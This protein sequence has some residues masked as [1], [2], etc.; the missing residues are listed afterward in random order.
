MH[1]FNFF[2]Y[3][4]ITLL[5]AL[6]LTNT[7]GEERFWE[8]PSQFTSVDSRFP[9]SISASAGGK[10]YSLLFFEEVEEKKSQL[11][12][13]AKLTTDGKMWRDIPRFAG[14]YSYVGSVP[15]QYATAYNDDGIVCVAVIT[16]IGT[17]SV[18]RTDMA[19]VLQG[20][21][22][23]FSEKALPAI[24]NPLLAPRIYKNG[25]N[26][27]TL[28]S[29]QGQE[30][31]F[32][33]LYS[34]SPDGEA[35][36]DFASF[37][38]AESTMN[39]FL[40]VL[41]ADDKVI[42]QAQYNNGSR[43]VY[44][45]Y[46]TQYNADSD[47]WEEARLITGKDSF[48]YEKESSRYDSYNNQ[49]PFVFTHHD[50]TYIAW[51]RS[52]ST[53]DQPHI[54]FSEFDG[55]NFV[56]STIQEL[57]TSGS[58]HR[59]ILFSSD[60]EALAILWFDNRRGFDSVF[61]G[62]FFAGE[63]DGSVISR[64]N[65]PSSFAYPVQVGDTLSFVWQQ[66]AKTKGKSNVYIL[67]KDHSVPRP[68]LKPISYTLGKRSTAKKVSAQIIAG[69][70]SSGIAGYS[71]IFTQDRDA[72]V[73]KVRK[74]KTK[75]NTM[76]ASANDDGL[77]YFK[78]RCEDYAGN[79]SDVATLSY[80]RDTTPPLKPIISEPNKDADG[81]ISSNT[82]S[83]SW[84]QNPQD[85]DV[86]G[87]SWSL[88]YVATEPETKTLSS[89]LKK[90]SGKLKS[91][92]PPRTLMGNKR[93]S[94][95]NNLKN[96]VYIFSVAAIDQVGNIGQ[97]ASVFVSLNKYVAETKVTAVDVN[98]SELHEISMSIFGTDFTYRGTISEVY[99]DRDGNA[100]Y[101]KV[102]YLANGDYEVNSDNRISGI[103]THDLDEGDYKVGLLHTKRGVYFTGD[104][105]HVEQNGT[106]KF[107]HEYDYHPI[108]IPYETKARFI[109]DMPLVLLC[110]V[111]ILAFCSAVGAIKGMT[112]TVEEL[113]FIRN[114]IVAIEEGKNMIKKKNIIS[115]NKQFGL[116]LKLVLFTVILVMM[117]VS[118]VSIP[119]G[120]FTNSI[121]E[122][123]LAS[124]LEERVNVLL[125]S[126]S[127]GV[128]AYLPLEN[129]LEL[130]N[131]PAQ[132]SALPE[133]MYATISG[134]P[135]GSGNTNLDYVWA[136][137]DENIA[138]KIDSEL[139]YGVS[140]FTDEIMEKISLDFV[141]LNSI[142]T[143][144][145]GAIA[146]SIAQLNAE[147]AELALKDDIESEKRLEELSTITMQLSSRLNQMLSDISS[148]TTGSYPTYDDEHIDPNENIYIFY[149]PVLYRQ[150]SEQN[151]I[152][153]IIYVTVDTTSLIK[154]VA[155]ARRTV[156]FTALSITLIAVI[157]GGV[158]AL[159]VASVIVNPV[160]K[161]EK[162]VA[163]ISSTKDKMKLA[164]KDILVKT[165]DEIAS[166]G[167]KINEMTHG[168][169][170]AAE[171]EQLMMDGKVV[172]QAFL[173]LLPLGKGK[174]SISEFKS[175][176]LHF[177]GYYE[178][179]SLVSGDYFDYRELDKQWFTVIK[180]DAS[181]HGVPAALIVTVVATFFRKYCEGW[182]FKKNGT[183]IGECVL[184]INEFLS[185]LGLQGKFA[186]IC[187]C[188]INMDSG[189]V[190]T[191]NA[192]DNI[193]HIYDGKQKKMIIR[194]MF[195]NPAAGN[196]SAQFVR[197]VLMQELEFKVEKIHLEKDDVLFLYTDG[198][199]ES[200]RKYRNTD[201]SEL[202]VEETS[203][204][205]TPYAHT[206]KVDHEQMEND[207][208][209]AIIE[210][211]MSKSTY[212]LEKKHNPLLDERLEFDFST[213]DGTNEDIIIALCSVEKVFRFYKSP[214]VTEVDTVRC[215]KKI[216]EFLSKHFNRYDY[217]CSRKNEAFENPIY[218]EYLFL[219]EDEQLD[220]LTMLSIT[221]Q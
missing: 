48:I 123:T 209:H 162:H 38:P 54:W 187:M 106:I 219:R 181:G 32:S 8:Y 165:N 35:W 27:F 194:K 2:K 13:S 60:G 202:E 93:Q 104:V 199:E 114:D 216:D 109:I 138:D 40:P 125:E 164:G 31:S 134:I 126:L 185:S 43:L 159:I 217:Y 119:L 198:I 19:S 191:C 82:F 84:K 34:S 133:A 68:S 186:A 57:T 10:N 161:L 33:M 221:R 53:S 101:D 154:S 22:V 184:Q 218:V 49:R 96:G 179:A 6:S 131:L 77:W 167:E 18:F 141:E 61:F 64:S 47:S 206:E 55:E 183:R 174:M 148:N 50:K 108:W 212:V 21:E 118:L 90:L 180:C 156:I 121:Q 177:F 9:S 29:S 99:L 207:R 100:P 137:N 78:A 135:S 132:T 75:D 24:E 173:P 44:Q 91:A 208:I 214:D 175:N 170:K 215:D 1:Y 65:T 58:A 149:K 117:V 85:T 189:D 176:H 5:F 103:K 120:V 20:G 79:W 4:F 37:K 172:Q 157:I 94:S 166:L 16:G 210:A 39:P 115:T 116:R 52:Y 155:A 28:F 205:G 95:Y 203:D 76:K 70:D 153:G 178:G 81:F 14:P 195:P 88:Q 145:A 107:S 124:G 201:F 211:V 71:W 25:E 122:K 140:R 150:G 112:R 26:G 146:D 67:E 41:F 73:P 83:I 11:Y 30:N 89:V 147:G 66:E 193:I 3:V 72:D 80:Y 142:V 63:L 59:P 97:A 188:L 204:E 102:L 196:M 168:L 129:I 127:S 171:E 15:D 7:I 105:F 190:Y 158:G 51:E 182:S 69:D 111:M 113:L 46:K 42:F 197:D 86:A 213:C 128:K 56:H 151:Y 169:V 144:Q 110:L 139:Q 23:I 74:D 163:M 192:G 152:R 220:D 200:T 17:L 36:S 130:S 143:E 136:T 98:E 45:L 12:I 87:Y 160:K 62:E 92:K